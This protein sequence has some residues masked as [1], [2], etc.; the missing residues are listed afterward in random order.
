MCVCAIRV[1]YEW[2]QNEFEEAILLYFTKSFLLLEF[3]KKQAEDPDYRSSVLFSY[4]EIVT[5]C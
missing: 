2:K 4:S 1:N 5:L 3:S